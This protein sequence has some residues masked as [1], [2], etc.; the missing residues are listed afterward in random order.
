MH[1]RSCVRLL[2]LATLSGV[3]SYA[4]DSLAGPPAGFTFNGKW[5]C[6][7]NFPGSGKPRA[8]HASWQGKMTADGSWIELS[9]LDIDPVGYVATFLIGSDPNKKEVV[10]F[11]ADN[12]GYAMLTGKGWQGK[13]LTLTMNGLASYEEFKNKPIPISRVTLEFQSTDVFTTTWEVKTGDDWVKD[14]YL[15]CKLT[16]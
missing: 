1:L 16:N 7:G 15:S 9:Y 12:K 5:D 6:H 3:W 14:D 13:A 11:V 10:T 2:T 4:A 8:H